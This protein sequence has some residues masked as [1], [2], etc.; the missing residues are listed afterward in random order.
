MGAGGGDRGVLVT[1]ERGAL[2]DHRGLHRDEGVGP[3]EGGSRLGRIPGREGGP[4]RL[5]VVVEERGAHQGGVVPVAVEAR[6]ELLR[7]LGFVRRDDEHLAVGFGD[8]VIHVGDEIVDGVGFAWPYGRADDGRATP[9]RGLGGGVDAEALQ[10][11]TQEPEQHQDDQAERDPRRDDV[12]LLGRFGVRGGRRFRHDAEAAGGIVDRVFEAR[13][14]GLQVRGELLVDADLGEELR[15]LAFDRREL[16]H[17]RLGLR[18]L[19]G[20]P[21]EALALAFQVGLRGAERRLEAG[22]LGVGARGGRAGLGRFPRV[23]AC[24]ERSDLL[25]ERLDPRVTVREAPARFGEL[26]AESGELLCFGAVGHRGRVGLRSGRA[27]ELPSE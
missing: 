26:A 9:E 22:V 1:R 20:L 7:E 6:R 19:R 25:L 18:R 11:S 13:S 2:R 16:L 17:T 21:F 3:G 12:P 4:Q 10:L 27:P 24:L 15:G 5:V 23:E 8:V 14:L